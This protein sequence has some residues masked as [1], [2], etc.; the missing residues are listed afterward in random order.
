MSERQEIAKEMLKDCC[1]SSFVPNFGFL[2]A[3][4]PKNRID[5]LYARNFSDSISVFPVERWQ[6]VML[7]MSFS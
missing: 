3:R 5:K 2:K 6:I 7:F 1:L 4:G